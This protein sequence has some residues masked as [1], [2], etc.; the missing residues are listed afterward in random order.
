MSVVAT[1]NWPVA[2]IAVLIGAIAISVAII[3]AI[4]PWLQRIALAKPNARSSHSVPTPQGGGIAVIAA[5]IIAAAGALY[6]LPSA[7]SAP[8]SLLPLLAAV[9]VIAAVGAADDIRPIGVAPRFFLQAFSVALVIFA[10]PNDLRIA[11]SMPIVLERLLLTVGGLWFVNLVNFMDGLD[12]MTAAEVVPIT[13]ALAI[14]GAFGF[15]PA[16]PSMISVALCGAM[17]GF[18]YFNRPVARLFLG[19]VG[20]L[21]IG[22]L[23]GWLLVQFAGRGALA[24]AILLP[25]YYLA[26]ATITLVRRLIRREKIWQAH[27]SHFYQR[28]TD[29]GFTVS[30]VVAYVFA[31]NVAL[32]ALGFATLAA[33]GPFNDAA[34]L[35]C[36]AVLVAW[37]LLAFSRGRRSR[38]S[39]A[40]QSEEPG[41]HNR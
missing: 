1:N 7:A 8:A 5:T 36:G 22:L 18:A 15:L 30:Q 12:W 31:V 9:I 17:I 35:V 25:L 29:R 38:H 28:A 4:R 33:P 37:L 40:E 41:N 2:V 24:A 3:V 14:F 20:S 19:D 6:L 32:A 11:P 39:G 26:D 23:L 10:L 34:A 13:A 27:R 21:P 16:A